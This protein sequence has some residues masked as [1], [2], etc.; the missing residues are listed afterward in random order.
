MTNPAI[1]LLNGSSSAGKSALARSLQK[2]LQPQPVVMSLDAFVFGLMPPSWHN[3]PHGTHFTHEP[4]GTTPLHLGPG[5]QAMV[6]AFHRSVAALA[7]CGLS[8]LV[9]DV[10]FEPWLLTDWLEATRGREVFFVGVH[11][12]LAEAERREI[13]R[14]DRQPGQARSQVGLV[15]AHGDYDFTVDTTNTI[16]GACADQIVAAFAA[17][18]GP[19]AFERLRGS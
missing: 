11:C 12:D 16:P 2:R 6:R 13:T 19:T 17:R 8:V 7:D 10:L 15:H 3:T 4:D 18:S 5:A 14:G 9:D 1:I